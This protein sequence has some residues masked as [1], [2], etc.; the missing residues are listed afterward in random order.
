M[1]A[2]PELG[3][4]SKAIIEV[5][6]LRFRDLDGDG[7][8]TPY[9][10]WRLTPRER[11]EDL[12]TRLSVEQKAG[13]MIIG[14][15]YMHGSPFVAENGGLPDFRSDPSV[16][17]RRPVADASGSFLRAEDG[18]STR[19]TITGE[20]LAE[21][22]LHAA[23]SRG[24]IQTRHQR[25]L[26]VRDNPTAA[27]LAA[28]SNQLQELA[29]DTEFGIPVML[30]SNPRNHAGN[31]AV[32]GIE[33]ASGVFSEWPGEL[34]LAAL[35]DEEAVEEFARVARREWRASGLHKMYGYMADVPTEPRWSRFSGTLGEDP[36]HVGALIAAMVRGFQGET[37]GRDSIAL[38]VKH[39][40]GGGVR[41]DGHDPHFA[42]GQDNEYPT[43]GSLEKYQLPPFE[44]AIDA[45][46]ASVMPYYSKP[47]NS[48]AGQLSDDLRGDDEQFEE[49]AF[50]YNTA[51]LTGLLREKLGFSGYINTDSGVLHGMAW[52][53]QEL[54]SVE[55]WVKLVRA[56]SDVV[57][58]ELD[59]ANLVAALRAGALEEHELDRP[60]TLLLQEMFALGLFEN[61]YV[62]AEKAETV[63]TDPVA[64][65][66]AEAAQRRSVTLLRN[67]RGLL[68]LTDDGTRIYVEAFA[69]MGAEGLTRTLRT[70][71]ADRMG[72]DRIVDD[73]SQADVAVVWVLPVISLFGGD[74][75]P[76]APISVEL[77]DRGID[78]ER[79]KAI[80]D[81]VPTALVV[82]FTNPW[83]IADVEPG[84]AAVLG[85]FGIT[86]ANLAAV[87]TGEDAPGGRLPLTVPRDA[88]A[89]AAS[90]RDVPGMQCG[91]DYVYVDSAGSAYAYGYGV[92]GENGRAW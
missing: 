63:T 81:A 31:T 42:W 17:T 57:S 25:R 82:S 56:G 44:A 26:I 24:A 35:M 45:G 14:S 12:L 19:Q 51:L 23:S 15:H 33:E 73:P 75:R 69:R 85:T 53:V 55:R 22:A 67:D 72:A 18:Y 21:P 20:P 37:L 9:E 70:A 61:P 48:S 40:P 28:W 27:D 10:D 83:V 86:S 77:A 49:V 87:L 5:D 30:T 68:P 79:V 76:G 78:V 89:V 52:G 6:G 91:D 66:A 80:E 16:L 36:A 84:A 54:T 47:V 46:V 1:T 2:Q 34:G 58:D 7:E 65:A 41:T 92:L 38:T 8:L 59:P 3:S 50:A 39:F 60:I 88:A 29:E 90:P 43:A 4:R 74:D 64:R 71:L 13:L 32:M 62:D 11:A